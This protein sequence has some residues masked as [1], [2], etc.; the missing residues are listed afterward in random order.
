MHGLCAWSREVLRLIL[1]VKIFH[2]QLRHVGAI[3]HRFHR[4]RLCSLW[5]CSYSRRRAQS[6]L[7]LSSRGMSF[8]LPLP[9]EGRK[10]VRAFHWTQACKFDP[11]QAVI[12]TAANQPENVTT[13]VQQHLRTLGDSV[14]NKV[15]FLT[16]IR[17]ALLK[18][19]LI[20]GIPRVCERNCLCSIFTEMDTIWHSMC[21]LTT[22]GI[23]D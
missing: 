16:R 19:S 8:P 23:G 1:S 17:E 12:F 10:F 6:R 5:I 18:A 4:A 7:I 20:C 11:A 22:W 15:L 9:F 14:P 2:D 21:H 13:M 3:K